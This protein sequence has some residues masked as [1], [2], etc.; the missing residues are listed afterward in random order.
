MTKFWVGDALVAREDARVSVLD[1]GVTVG[2]GVF[3]TLLVRDGTPFAL[4]RHLARLARSMAGLGIAAPEPDRLR[5]AVDA[6][7]AS[8]G[9]EA[10]HARLRITVTSGEGPAGSERGAG[11]ST[12]IVTLTPAATWPTTTTLATV[13]WVRNERSATVGLKTT[14]Y[15]VPK[16][17]LPPGRRS[18][19]SRSSA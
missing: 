3:E 6:V 7:V 17:R 13:A 14:S 4:T 15:A 2:D 11:A 12:L 16:L 5:R 9:A 19:P 1:H 18:E 8:A 10:R